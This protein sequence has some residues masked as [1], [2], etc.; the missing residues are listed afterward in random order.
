MDEPTRMPLA[1]GN[2]LA[3][4]GRLEEALAAYRT[5]LAH[6]PDNPEIRSNLG[7]VLLGLGRTEE[8]LATYRE[9]LAVGFD[10][11]LVY[12]NM[13]TALRAL[14][15]PEAALPAFV[16]ALARAPGF[17]PAHNNRGNALRD[18]GR[19]AEAAAAYLEALALRPGDGGTRVN[20]SSVLTLLHEQGAEGPAAAAALARRWRAAHPD[21]PMARHVAAAMTGGPPPVRAEDGYVRQLFDGFAAGFDQRLAALDYRVP[22]LIAAALAR[23]WPQ[24]VPGQRVLDAGCGTGLA[25]AALRPH[26]R[27]LVGIDLSPEMLDLARQRGLYD[28]L[29]AVELTAFLGSHREAF[30]LIVAADVLCYFGALDGVL[31]A[32]A[33]ALRPGGRL[34]FTVEQ[35][36][37]PDAPPFTLQPNGRYRHAP[38]A[39]TAALAATTLDA[40]PLTAV[41]LRRENGRDVPG[42]L[43]EA[44]R[45]GLEG[46]A[47]PLAPDQGSALDPPKAGG[48]WNP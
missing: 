26:A 20:L 13:G 19:H 33:A 45:V 46:G 16:E 31:K 1:D 43:V 4:A 15:R 17:A 29:E 7:N 44:G 3:A 48:P 6:A 24:P 32:A 34:I 25:A 27:T 5:A 11:P 40:P 22:E 42:V 12:Y 2:R 21:D 37:R 28:E 9:V 10:H 14:G 8:A 41:T 38:A 23:R 18:L 47:S 35:D 30:D 39:V 36:P